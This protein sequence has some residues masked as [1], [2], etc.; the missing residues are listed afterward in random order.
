[1]ITNKIGGLI[2]DPTM[3]FDWSHILKISSRNK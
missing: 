3:D 2:A 1:V